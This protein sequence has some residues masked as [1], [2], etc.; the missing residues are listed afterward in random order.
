[1]TIYCKVFKLDFSN[2]LV[3]YEARTYW[4]HPKFCLDRKYLDKRGAAFSFQMFGD[5][6]ANEESAIR[7]C[8]EYARRQ[9][10]PRLSIARTTEVQS[11]RYV[12][13]PPAPP[14]GSA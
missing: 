4:P 3:R 10:T 13:A 5:F 11:L 1:M 9:L 14:A 6:F 8:E 2:G 7:A 12:T